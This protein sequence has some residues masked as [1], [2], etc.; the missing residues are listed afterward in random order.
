MYAL[1]ALVQ[2]HR[3]AMA[4]VIA[5]ALLMKAVVPAGFMVGA[6]ARVLTIELCADAQGERMVRQI[7]I[8]TEPSGAE[9]Q[10]QHQKGAGLC[11]YG[12]LGFAALGGADPIQLAAALAFVLTLG[13]AALVVPAPRTIAHLRPPLRGPPLL[14]A[15]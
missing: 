11:P 10:A 9:A 15:I 13:F 14:P 7:A 2:R 3:L 8:G 1:R 6:G 4:M 12:A 5:A